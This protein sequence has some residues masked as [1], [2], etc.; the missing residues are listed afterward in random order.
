MNKKHVAMLTVAGLCLALAGCGAQ[1]SP[2]NS[3][4]SSSLLASKS[5]EK[6]SADNLSPQQMVSVVTTYAGNKYGKDWASTAKAAHKSSLQVDLY[7][8]SRYQLSDKG[9]GVAYNVHADNQS[10][11]LVYTV[12]GNNVTIY[13]NA[14]SSKDAK[15]LG[16]VSRKSMV[17][18]LNKN[19]QSAYANQLAKKAQVNDKRSG[20]NGSSSSSNSST[21]TGKYGNA[22]AL[23]VTSD[24]EGT[25]YSKDSQITFS[26]NT[27]QVEGHT[28][29]IYKQS[30]AFGENSDNYTNRSIQDA[31]KDWLR[32]FTF[33]HDGMHWLNL[34]G[35]TQ[36]AGDGSY[37][38][39]HTETIDG[40]QV[41]VLVEGGGAEIW[42]DQ[43]YYQSPSMA[44]Q[45][46]H[47]KFDDLHYY[48]DDE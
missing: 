14:S 41:K 5:S 3:G 27:I 19:G 25:W 6:I 26:K 28:Y 22:G 43:V 10:S 40:Q 31:T 2:T 9:Q 12:D 29:H 1:S 16:T 36:G 8:A 20:D 45:N 23:N 15:K 4:N 48:S 42:V 47:R 46:A 7:N 34:R 11:K 33:D 44:K 39:V 38:A 17:N 24:M 30:K 13:S 37:Y 32:G 21:S 35:W 18:Y